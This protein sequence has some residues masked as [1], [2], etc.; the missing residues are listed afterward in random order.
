MAND[1][2]DEPIGA[3][4]DTTNTDT[5]NSTDATSLCT[6]KITD[7]LKKPLA[8]DRKS[9]N[10]AATVACLGYEENTVSVRL[11]VCRLE[12]AR[13]VSDEYSALRNYISTTLAA[14]AT[15]MATNVEGYVTR[16][17]ELSD[18]LN[19]TL[20][21]LKGVKSHMA[22]VNSLACKLETAC[23]DSCTAE[24]R[25]I[26]DSALGK[27]VFK[28]SANEL[29]KQVKGEK[30]QEGL[31]TVKG[32]TH[33]A[34]DLFD[35]GVKYAGIQA[36]TNVSS[37]TSLIDSLKESTGKIAT[38]VNEQ[39]DSLGQ[40]IMD[41]QKALDEEVAKLSTSLYD[42]RLSAQVATGLDE[43]EEELT[44][45]STVD[46][47]ALDYAASITELEANC[48][49]VVSTFDKTADCPPNDGESKFYS[50]DVP[51]C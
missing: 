1:M 27:N 29:V 9:A 6:K 16:E 10:G 20:E 18:K 17:S 45:I 24:E 13:L 38:N 8:D 14:H 47:E 12:D 46:C 44:S 42:R 5:D 41:L 23:N 25:K 28:R 2:T 35:M 7:Y 30:D 3:G 32:T 40:G 4:D 21:A 31:I 39:A 33:H 43:L 36:S 37:L 26:M 19:T 49:A 48:L 22:K 50:Q 51:S 34:D 11:H 15:G